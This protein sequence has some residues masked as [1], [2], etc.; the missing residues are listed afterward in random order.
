[1]TCNHKAGTTFK[2]CPFCRIAELEAVVKELVELQEWQL[3]YNY[4]TFTTKA[5]QIIS[6]AKSRAGRW[7]K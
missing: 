3:K 4:S 6:R 2:G 7:M 5:E 1:M